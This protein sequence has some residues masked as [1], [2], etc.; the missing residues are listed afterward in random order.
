M[1]DEDEDEDLLRLA[2]IGRPNVGKSTL[3]N[4]LLGEERVL[5]FDQPGTTRDTI[6]T[7]ERDGRQ[8][9]LIDTAGV[10]RR[11][12]VTEVVEKFSTIKALQAIDRAHVVVLM[13]D[14]REGLTDQDT[15]LLGH[16]LN[17]GRALVIA[18]N[19]WDGLDADHREWCR[20]TRP[21]TD[22]CQLGETGN[23]LGAARSGIQELIN[24]VQVA[25]QERHANSVPRS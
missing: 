16:I 5:A 14:A 12:K 6:S 1:E 24:A 8:Y 2:I 11:S 17:Q 9:E 19:K 10:R 22:L 13:L 7:L 23:D 4:R 25:L 15:T 21:E 20:G 3:V 18:L